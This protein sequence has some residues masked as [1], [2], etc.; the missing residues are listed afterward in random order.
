MTGELHVRVQAMLYEADARTGFTV[1]G[2]LY[3]VTGRG[4]ALREVLLPLG[5]GVAP[6]VFPV[7]PGRW[8]VEASLPSGDLLCE[9][10]QVTEGSRVPVDLDATD[11]PHETHSWQYVV[12]NVEPGHIYHDASTVPVP[13][14]SG[15]RSFERL[16]PTADR[17]PGPGPAPAGVAL[18][19]F[20]DGGASAPGVAALNVLA[21]EEATLVPQRLASSLLTVRGR[22]DHVEPATTDGTSH[23]FRF[24]A[25]GPTSGLVPGQRQY[26][27]AAAGGD[28]YLVTLPCPWL[29]VDGSEAVVEVLVNSRQSPTGSA[30]SV[31]VRDPAIGAGLAYLANGALARAATVFRDVQAMLYGKVMNHLAAAAA[32]YVLVGTDLAEEPQEWDQWLENLREWFPQL[33]DGAILWGVRRLRLAQTDEDVEAARQSLVE[34]FDRG[35]PAYTLGLSWLID[36][37]SEF[38]DDPEC[39]ERLE[40]V[41]RLS[42]RVDMREPFVVVRLGRRTP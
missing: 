33:S 36:S 8:L 38:P 25:G 23:L 37:L 26:L 41:R 1:V 15:S 5:A 32:G 13:N 4:T 14:S 35:L 40:Q 18:S 19:W 9:E 21:E 2:N 12:G 30:I 16:R 29:T 6:A 7:A 34:G 24:G 42:W 31:T 27:T 39:A 10:V 11:S 20:G 17:D 3:P 28:A 22:L